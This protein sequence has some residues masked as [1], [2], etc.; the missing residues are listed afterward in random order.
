MST[1]RKNNADVAKRKLR[2]YNGRHKGKLCVLCETN[3]ADFI[4][5]GSDLPA[6]EECWESKKRFKQ[7][8]GQIPLPGE[9]TH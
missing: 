5:V 6:C 4:S 3:E 2:D 8:R 9:R 7:E 1:K